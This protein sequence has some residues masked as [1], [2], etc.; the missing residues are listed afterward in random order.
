MDLDRHK[1]HGR[2]AE[3]LGPAALDADVL[4]RRLGLAESAQADYASVSSG[5]KAMLDAYAAGVNAFLATTRSLPIEYRLLD[6]SPEPW[7]PWH[8]LS[9][10]KI[11][12]VFMGTFEAKL[13]R[14]RVLAKA[15]P[16]VTA[17]LFPSSKP[18]G[19]VIIPPGAEF[20]GEDEDIDALR[21]SANAAGRQVGADSGE[22]EGGSNSWALA[23]S[24][25]ASGK[26]LLAGD[27]H[28]APDTP[29]VYYQNHISCPEF[30]VIGLSFAGLPGFHHFG[31]N[32][33]VAW[34]VTHTAADYQD[35]YVERFA[36]RSD[37]SP[38]RYEFRGEWLDATTSR[39]TVRV[40]GARDVDIDVV[41]TRHG[42]IV[43]GDPDAGEAIALRYTA[44]EAGR[45]WA[46]AILDMMLASDADQFEEAMR[47]WVDP[48]NNM[49]CADVH[50]NISYQMRGMLPIRTRGNGWVPVP[51]WTGEHEWRGFVPFEEAPRT[52][53]PER[54]F[55]VT[56]NNRVI[57]S[58][59]PHYISMDFAPDYRARRIAGQLDGLSGATVEAMATL[60]AD[61]TSILAQRLVPLLAGA[62]VSDSAAAGLVER[63]RGWD[64]RMDRDGVEPT[65]YAAVLS[66]L[67]RRV[68]LALLGDRAHRRRHDGHRTRRI[69]AP[70][71][72]ERVP[73]RPDRTRRPL[74]AVRRRVVARAA[75]GGDRRRGIVAARDVGRRP[76]RMAMGRAA[77]LGPRAPVVGVDARVRGAARPALRARGGR[78]RHA[79][80]G[81]LRA[82]APVRPHIDV[83]GALCVRPRRLGQQSLGRAAGLVGTTRAAPTTPTRW[84][85]GPT[86][87]FIPMLYDWGS[88]R[89]QAE[90]MQR[91][92][93]A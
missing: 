42:P 56:A 1:A 62:G 43:A 77:P 45:P 35:L 90:T 51:G 89:V 87:S 74:V 25:T 58:S 40:R 66:A 69:H 38:L 80:A 72:A 13:W 78:R 16:E 70:A 65:I 46:N 32:R 36:E 75:R 82:C 18:G 57:G 64:C 28:R 34:C 15:G 19:L 52:R 21:T 3:L 26:P 17:L 88:I 11:R 79:P 29:N 59:Y 6:L 12:H 44:T 24:R 81:G 5:A 23:G 30:D 67:E 63:L 93:P 61:T 60:H 33:S 20:E 49:L 41:S 8:C 39:E 92:L 83:G 47:P 37:D 48:A 22:S 54:G 4:V 50:G 71:L 76:G 55:I 85:V 27:P 68:T 53:N 10:F 91:L 86:S 73:R 84:S 14:A 9:V 7:L 2:S 31:H